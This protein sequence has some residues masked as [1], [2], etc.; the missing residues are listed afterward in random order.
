MIIINSGYLNKELDIQIFIIHHYLH[1]FNKINSLYTLI[2]ITLILS[3]ENRDKDSF[4]I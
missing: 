4:R 1:I 2:T 3:D